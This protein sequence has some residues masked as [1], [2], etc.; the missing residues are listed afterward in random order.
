MAI[1]TYVEKHKNQNHKLFEVY[2]HGHDHKG[3]RI[4]R[5]RRGIETLRQA[6]VIEFE[7]KRELA[8]LREE[9]SSP[10]W[11]EWVIES[12]STMKMS[13]RLSTVYTYEKAA[14]K[15][16]DKPWGHLEL[17]QISKNDVHELLHETMSKNETPH[18][19][20]YVLKIIKRIFQMAV[21]HGHLD[22]N[23]CQG[24]TV[25]VPESE[26]KVLTNQ[27]SAKLLKEAKNL[28]HRFYPIWV[29]ALFTGMRSGELYALRWSDVDLENEIIHVSRSWSSKNGFTATKNQK[30]RI[31]PISADL[32]SFLKE[33]KLQ[34]AKEEFV[35]PHPIEWTRGDGADVIRGFC[36]SIG[37]TP[38]KFHDLRATFI[39]NLLSRGESLARVMAIVGHADID[40]TNVYLRLAGVELKGGTDKLGYEIPRD[41]KATIY[42]LPSFGVGQ[43]E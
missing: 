24:M 14:S 27:E 20:K 22:R 21:D 3:S 29:V 1:R 41:T 37:I 18:T 42:Q 15:W 26:K 4:Q 11:S 17:K 19:W 8:R 23:P 10:T 38:I 5:K 43:S 2:V 6:Q 30:T 9:K 13:Y 16:M 40:T 7:L 32:L 36:K 35:L 33:L 31:V 28:D 39:T 34:R 25:K 12:I